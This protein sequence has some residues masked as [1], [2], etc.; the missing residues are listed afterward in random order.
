MK[1]ITKEARAET[2]QAFDFATHSSTRPAPGASI[3]VRLTGSRCRCAVCGQ[4]FN[5]VSTFDRHRRGNFGN[6]GRN[7]SCLTER[8]LVARGW[9][10]NFTG[11]W[12]E[13]P[14]IDV[15]PRNGDR[16]GAACPVA[17]GEIAAVM[18]PV[19]VLGQECRPGS[20]L[21]RGGI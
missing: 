8:E 9:R 20:A 12:I 18:R 13:R 5:S 19:A 14:R 7:R 21:A 3:G 4:V 1:T 6:A 11:F 16:V 17:G 15:T 2:G 10:R